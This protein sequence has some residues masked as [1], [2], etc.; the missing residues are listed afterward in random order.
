M[1]ARDVDSE[2]IALSNDLTGVLVKQAGVFDELS[3]IL[4]DRHRVNE[5]Y[6]SQ[7]AF[8]EALARGLLGDSFGTARDLVEAQRLLQNRADR[9]RSKLEGTSEKAQDCLSRLLQLRSK[10]SQKYGV[11]LA[12][13]P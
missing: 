1:P 8:A 6:S 12:P 13:D 2:L 7:E 4:A 11:E 5:Y 9:A 3:R 10:L